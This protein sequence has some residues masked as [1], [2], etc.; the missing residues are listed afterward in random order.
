VP[1]ALFRDEQLNRDFAWLVSVRINAVRW[2]RQSMI[3]TS[4]FCS[5]APTRANRTSRA[6]PFV[7]F[8]LPVQLGEHDHGNAQFLA[9]PL[10]ALE[11]SATSCCRFSFLYFSRTRVAGSPPRSAGP[12]ALNHSPGTRPDLIHV[13]GASVVDEDGARRMS[14]EDRTMASGALGCSLPLVK[15]SKFTPDREQTSA[16]PIPPHPFRARKRPPDLQSIATCSMML[17]AIAVFPAL[18][19]RQ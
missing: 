7:L 16:K 15:S 6:P 11:M 13:Q 5:M 12:C 3:T 4:A 1:V 10:S 14:L 2:L 18:A 8:N 9:S 19:A 17:A